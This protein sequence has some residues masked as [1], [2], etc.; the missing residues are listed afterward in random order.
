VRY[1]DPNVAQS[2]GNFTLTLASSAF[3]ATGNTSLTTCTLNYMGQDVKPSANFTLRG[4]T[5]R[6]CNISAAPG[7]FEQVAYLAEPEES[8]ARALRVLL[9]AWGHGSVAVSQISSSRAFYCNVSDGRA[10]MGKSAYYVDCNSKGHITYL[11]LD[12]PKGGAANLRIDD[13]A[14]V[15]AFLALEKLEH[16]YITGKCVCGLHCEGTQIPQSVCGLAAACLL[17][18]KEP[19]RGGLAPR[20]PMPWH[21]GQQLACSSSLQQPNLPHKTQLLNTLPALSFLHMHL[22]LPFCTRVC[23]CLQS[24]MAPY[25]LN[26]ARCAT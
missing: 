16:L 12:N 9:D 3:P 10:E 23:L 13:M 8:Q 21:A 2:S 25:R 15:S 1:I 20:L 17:S 26:W 6:V 18:T 7:Q 22:P 14:V 5:L 4:K 11:E 24:T 19:P